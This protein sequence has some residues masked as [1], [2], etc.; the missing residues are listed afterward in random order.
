MQL[1][2]AAMTLPAGTHLCELVACEEVTGKFA[3]PALKWVFE[4]PLGD[5]AGKQAR[6]TTGLAAAADTAL[7]Q[8]INWLLGRELKRGERLETND[9]IGRR[10][11]VTLAG[12]QVIKVVAVAEE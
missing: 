3:E 1:E 6:R 12:G 2:G 4:C 5:N 8:M 9:L 10:Y 7:G 11:M